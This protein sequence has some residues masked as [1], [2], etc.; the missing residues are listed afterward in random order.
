MVAGGP[1]TGKT[2]FCLQ[3][4]YNA[5]CRG[6]DC[7]YITMEEPPQRLR[8]HMES[9]GWKVKPISEN[10]EHQRLRAG[11]G[12]LFIERH[13]AILTARAVEAL[14]AE[15]AGELSIKLD[16]RSKLLPKGFEPGLFV[17]DS[18]S[19]LESAFAG[20]P[21]SYRIYIEQLFRMLE[22]TDMTSLLVTETEEAPVR[23]SRSGVEEFLAD[24]VF[25]LYNLKLHD[26]RV[27]GMEILKLRGAK[28]KR[29]L[30]PMEITDRGIVVYPKERVYG[31]EVLR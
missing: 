27:R 12:R 23:F 3:V 24:G 13:D 4:L 16:V 17:L 30:A 22:E 21:E 9:F 14:L 29:K 8:M 20:R 31:A 28:H 7:L 1:G 6:K 2:I 19:A 26:T 25:V 11:K 5:A 18:I 10:R 15:A